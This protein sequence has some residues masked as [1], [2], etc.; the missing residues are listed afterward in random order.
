M[1]PF[2]LG[3]TEYVTEPAVLPVFCGEF[4]IVPEPLGETVEVLIVP[5]MLLTQF[6]ELPAM[7]AVGV[8]LKP[9]VLQRVLDAGRLETCG[10][11]FTVAV[12]VLELAHAPAVAITAYVTVPLFTPSTTANVCSMLAP[13]PLAA[14]LT[15]DCPCVQLMTVP[16]TALGFESVKEAVCAEQMVWLAVILNVGIGLTVTV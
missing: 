2:R 10:T 3:V 14:P 5:A 15:L 4:A 13:L 11:G 8:K 1:Q 6:S 12:A 9:A 16:A 7:L